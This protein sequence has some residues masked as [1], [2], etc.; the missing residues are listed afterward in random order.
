MLIQKKAEKFDLGPRQSYLGMI[1]TKI[2]TMK[3]RQNLIQVTEVVLV[4]TGE[5]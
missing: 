1:K 2:S 3:S 4:G 5:D